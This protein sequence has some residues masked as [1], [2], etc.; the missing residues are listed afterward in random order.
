MTFLVGGGAAD[1]PGSVPAANCFRTHLREAIEL[2][3]ERMPK[4]AALT[5]GASKSISRRLIWSERLALPPAWYVDR[6]AAKYLRAGI[7]VVCDEFVPMALT[8]EFRERSPVEPL[9]LADFRSP[10]TRRL[11]RAVETSFREGGFPAVSMAVERELHR[12]EETPTY[13]CMLR[14]LLESALRIANVAPVHAAEAAGI[15]MPTP[16]GLSWLMIRLHLMTF[17]EAARLDRMA[18]PIQAEGIPIL[19]QDVPPIAP[20]PTAEERALSRGHLAEP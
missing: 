14:H 17:E 9:P 10:D 6:R 12:L 16:E 15:D 13:H 2:N 5:G 4:Y 18:A 8:P 20:F 11:R 1:L 3:Q 19:C 7:P